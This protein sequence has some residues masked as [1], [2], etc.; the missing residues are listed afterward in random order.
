MEIAANRQAPVLTAGYRFDRYEL[1]KSLAQGPIA[2]LWEAKLRADTGPRRCTLTTVSV[3]ERSDHARIV[4][5]LLDEAGAAARVVHPN[6]AQ[7][8]E[9]GEH[10]RFVYIA[11]EWIEG[12]SVAEL[13][14]A[15]DAE[16]HHMPVAAALRVLCDACAGLH[17]AHELRDERGEP[18]GIVHGNVGMQSILMGL[19]GH[20][21]VTDFGA[22][23]TRALIAHESRDPQ[24]RAEL[25]NHAPELATNKPFDRRA[26]IW[27]LG[28]VLYELLGSRP[29]YRG[30]NALQM[31]MLLSS[32]RPPPRLG[33][34][35]PAPLEAIAQRCLAFDPTARFQTAADLR[36]ALTNAMGALD[37]HPGPKDVVACLRTYAP[38]QFEVRP[39]LRDSK[40]K[41]EAPPE[42]PENAAEPTTSVDEPAQPFGQGV[43]LDL[44]DDK[45]T[46]VM[47]VGYQESGAGPHVAAH[48]SPEPPP[49]PGDSA[50]GE[51]LP[52][53]L[54]PSSPPQPAPLDSPP[55]AVINAPPPAQLS[56]N[57]PIELLGAREPLAVEQATQADAVSEVDI[58]DVA[59]VTGLR[60]RRR[61]MRW[62]AGFVFV[63]IVVVG[64]F[65]AKAFRGRMA[66]S[67]A[68]SNSSSTAPSSSAQ[69]AD[70]QAPAAVSASAQLSASAPAALSAS[71]KSPSAPAPAWTGRT[72]GRTDRSRASSSASAPGL[73]SAAGPGSGAPPAPASTPS[74]PWAIDDGL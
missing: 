53:C 47:E 13:K 14:R 46:A 68:D 23:R 37:L 54:Q 1:L 7:V 35:A 42:A 22:G 48:V 3:P 66:A 45:P 9:A 51:E 33:S 63:A 15:I 24:H 16:G 61:R 43:P 2:M 20:A 11:A 5:L 52:A 72:R 6:L 4:R 64:A 55:I 50:I 30:E 56:A 62:V 70:S 17:A 39:A 59:A 34:R 18:L 19:D 69:I 36:A 8:L 38:Q 21:R 41:L 60:T 49:A 29:P 74:T 27:G 32:G 44:G 67:R 28:A 73:S 40:P 26:D 71:A 12:C 58:D 10:E 25:V 57:D 65:A 31:L